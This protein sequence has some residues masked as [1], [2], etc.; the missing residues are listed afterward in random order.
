MSIFEDSS[1][2]TISILGCGWLGFPLARYLIR[3]GY[4]VK[5]STTTPERV[6]QLEKEGIKPYVIRLLPEPEGRYLDQF[7][8]TDVLIIAVPPRVRGGMAESFHPTQIQHIIEEV[9]HNRLSKVI[10]IGSTSVYP[11][12]RKQVT[13]KDAQGHDS[14][15]RA[16]L[17]AE[18]ILDDHH[19]IECT[20]LRCGGLMGYDRIPGKYFAGKTG[21]TTALVPVNYIHRDDV[22]L[23]IA[24]IIQY[25]RWEFTYNLVAP[26]HPTRQEVYAKNAREFGFEPPQ[27]SDQHTE[28]FKIVSS[29]NVISDLRYR[30]KYPDPMNFYYRMATEESSVKPDYPTEMPDL[31]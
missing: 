6:E 20:I 24:G 30:F 4:T 13:E 11:N 9:D 16:L 26:I 21:L 27:F 12:V 5:G 28:E 25:G 8:D 14:V 22:I 17:T 31:Y 29:Y 7:L 18:E 3:Q 23:I 1:I 15:S 19:A 10:Y 2:K